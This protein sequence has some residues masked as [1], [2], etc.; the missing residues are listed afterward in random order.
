[1]R[2]G[3]GNMRL[4]CS[5]GR[6]RRWWMCG[7]VIVLLGVLAAAVSVVQAAE[8]RVTARAAIIV[9]NGSGEVLWE[10]NP[11]LPLPP[12]S[13]TKVL[14][15]ILAIESRRLD[16]WVT[17]SP[18]AAAVPPSKIG[19]RAGERMALGDLLY[20]VLLNSA[21]DASTVVAEGLAGSE[22]EFALKMNAK[23]RAIGARSSRFVNPHGLTQEG[24]ISTVRDLATIFRYGLR[25]PEL[26]EILE[27]PRITVPL[28][29]RRVRTVSLNSHNRLLTGYAH[30]VTG[31]TGYPR[32]AGRCFVG[33]ATSDGREVVI[34]MLGSSDLWGDARRL[35]GH[36]FGEPTEV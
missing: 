25:L 26:R 2:C 27:T 20:A 34:A 14:T 12:A 22:T 35:F 19:L 15:A 1:M 11:D 30:P 13:T 4:G 16:D 7:R 29:S 36:A 32:P 9:D 18:D 10:R 23:A 3:H 33:S 17:V 28:Q 6:A 21:N 24:H 5:R 31:K 8:P